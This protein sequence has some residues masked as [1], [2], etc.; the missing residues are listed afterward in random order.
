MSKVITDIDSFLMAATA[1]D[2]YV[3]NCKKRNNDLQKLQD[4]LMGAWR[5]EDYLKFCDKFQKVILDSDSNNK[6]L[7]TC[8]EQF[9]QYLKECAKQYSSAQENAQNRFSRC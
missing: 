5:G 7:I 9:S 6:Q 1:I 8:L 2:D 3:A 4:E